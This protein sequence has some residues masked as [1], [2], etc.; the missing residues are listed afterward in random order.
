M[1]DSDLV[2]SVYCVFA[3]SD[4]C[5]PFVIRQNDLPGGKHRGNNLYQT[6]QLISYA[7]LN[8]QA[9]DG[10]QVLATV[11]WGMGGRVE[12]VRC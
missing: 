6:D 10:L 5:H 2:W 1:A 7:Y 8:F 11:V 9:W 4:P 3:F 12:V